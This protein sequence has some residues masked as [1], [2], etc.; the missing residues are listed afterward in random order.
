MVQRMSPHTECPSRP[1]YTA[2]EWRALQSLR[3]RYQE[4]RDLWSER[5]LAHLRFVRWL[6]QNGRQAED[7]GPAA[8]GARAAA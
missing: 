4:G 7:G 1:A 6:A 2:D 3:L 8:V 5:E